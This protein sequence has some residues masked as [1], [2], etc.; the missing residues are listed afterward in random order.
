[1]QRRSTGRRLWTIDGL[2]TPRSERTWGTFMFL[3]LFIK[4]NEVGLNFNDSAY[5]SSFY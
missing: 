4:V 3:K 5:D 1:M 2:K